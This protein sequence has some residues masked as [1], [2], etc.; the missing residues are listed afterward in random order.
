MP[1]SA[2]PW[3]SA[4]MFRIRKASALSCHLLK[5]RRRRT[6]PKC[7][8]VFSPWRRS[9]LVMCFLTRQKQSVC[10]FITFPVRDSN[11]GLCLFNPS[12]SC[13]NLP[14]P[15]GLKNVWQQGRPSARQKPRSHRLSAR[16][17]R[18]QRLT[19]ISWFPSGCHRTMKG[20]ISSLQTCL[21]IAS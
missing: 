18:V 20:V 13:C 7:L 15:R 4:H 6:L 3:S 9:T 19:K 10:S 2:A 16:G 17:V 1:A 8:D 21:N 5:G 11:R 12:H 14:R